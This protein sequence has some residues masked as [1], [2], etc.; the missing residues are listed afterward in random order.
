MSTNDPRIEAFLAALKKEGRSSPVDWP[1]F[2]L[3]LQSKKQS[4]QNDPP[5][6]LILA[7]CGESDASKH[8]RLSSQLDWALANDCLD[9]AIHYLEHVPAEQWNSCPLELWHQDSY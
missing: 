1:R 3:L 9:D 5:V 8:H 6:P 7:A 2:Y 4:G